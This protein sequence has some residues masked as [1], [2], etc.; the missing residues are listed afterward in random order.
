MVYGRIVR[1]TCP[2]AGVVQPWHY[3]HG[4]VVLVKIL[5]FGLGFFYTVC[6]RSTLFGVWNDCKVYMSNWLVLSDLDLSFVDQWSKLFFLALFFFLILLANHQLYLLF[7]RIVSCTCLPD[8]V[9]LT[10]T[11]LSWFIGQC[12]IFL[13]LVC[14]LETLSNRSTILR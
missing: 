12:L 5:C 14:F 6:N 13:G 1:C 10:M 3:F 11:S 2:L 8:M 7:W 9:H 4:S